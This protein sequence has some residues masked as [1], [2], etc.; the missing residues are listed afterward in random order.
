MRR[1]WTDPR[2]LAWMLLS[3]L[4]TPALFALKARKYFGRKQRSEFD[5]DRW[6]LPP[7]TPEL[8]EKALQSGKIHVVFVGAS[9]GEVM[10]VDRVAAEL[11]Q[12]TDDIAVTYCVRDPNTRR[13]FAQ[14]HPTRPLAIWPFDYMVPAAKWV[15]QQRPDV[16]VFTERFRF[17][18][19]SCV[20]A[21]YGA[22][23]AVMN[24][25]C[26]FRDSIFYRLSAPLYRWQFA[27]FDG[28]IM[29]RE[30]FFNAAHKFA[31][32]GC[33]I[34]NTGDLK[35]DP[36][37]RELSPEKSEAVTRWLND[38]RTEPLLIAGSTSSIEEETMILEA[39]RKVREKLPCRLLM[40]VRRM[41]RI[42]EVVALT[43]A[44]GFTTSRRS[45]QEPA[46][47]VYIL[48]T[49]GELAFAY[50]F[51][52]AVYVGGSYGKGDGHNV[53]EPLEWGAPVA[54]GMNRGHFMTLQ[55]MCENAGVGTRIPDASALAEFFLHFM[56]DHAHRAQV[57]EAGIRLLEQ[58]RGAVARTVEGLLPLVEAARR[59]RTA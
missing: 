50:Q 54:Y 10:M 41:D 4:L 43:H 53:L 31:K 42:D 6:N 39:F 33:I 51:G 30:D 17:T 32:P 59:E 25:R 5:P 3:T 40:A 12:A 18:V 57:S 48:D 46:A 20:A 58:S 23:V 34:R 7:T 38:G 21:R 13:A 22:K 9:F 29:Q 24:G 19:F 37:R 14:S 27:A 45:K 11:E 1:V 36:K 55:M 35:A 44:Q 15:D 56:T 49:L 47:D 26:R 52:V 2:L 8:T 16:V 28:L